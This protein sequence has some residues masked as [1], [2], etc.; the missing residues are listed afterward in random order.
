MGYFLED[1]AAFMTVFWLVYVVALLGSG[2]E[3]FILASR[4]MP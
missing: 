4:V 1:L 3:N 2:A